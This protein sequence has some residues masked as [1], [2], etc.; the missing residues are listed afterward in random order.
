MNPIPSQTVPAKGTVPRRPL[1]LTPQNC[2][3]AQMR[4]PKFSAAFLQLVR[5][6]RRRNT[7]ATWN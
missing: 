2:Q 7:P 4:S 3:L 6:T 1:I 5:I